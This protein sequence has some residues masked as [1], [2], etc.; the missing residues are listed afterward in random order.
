MPSQ[1]GRCG[2][3]ITPKE[4]IHTPSAK[5]ATIPEPERIFTP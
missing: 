1:T 4:A 5:A 3:A 2:L